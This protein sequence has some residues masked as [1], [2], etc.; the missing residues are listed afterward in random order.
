MIFETEFPFFRMRKHP[1]QKKSL[2]SP[3]KQLLRRP[4]LRFLI[5]ASSYMPSGDPLTVSRC[6]RSREGIVDGE[7]WSFRKMTCLMMLYRFLIALTRESAEPVR[8]RGPLFL[9][10]VFQ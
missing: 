1:K 9:W 6:S 7:K 8:D 4:Q 10:C 5:R 3:P 2:P